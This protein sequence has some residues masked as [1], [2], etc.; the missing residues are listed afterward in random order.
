M[1]AKLSRYSRPTAL[2]L[3]ILERAGRRN[4][5]HV[6]VVGLKRPAD[7]GR[8]AARFVLQL[9]QPLQVLDP[10]G[11]RFDV[12]EHHRGRAAAAQLVPHAIHVQPIVGQ[13]F[14]ARDLAA[15]AIDQNLRAAAGQAAQPG[16]LQPL[17]HRAQRQLR[18]LGEVMNLRRAEAVDVDLRKARLMSRSSSSY[19]SSLK[20]GCRP[21]CIR[22]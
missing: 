4:V 6:G 11:Q 16:R 18:D 7:E 9:P 8:E 21:P 20:S 22:I 19:H 5:G 10:L 15:D 13:H 1:L 12:A 14:A 17:E 2:R 3:E